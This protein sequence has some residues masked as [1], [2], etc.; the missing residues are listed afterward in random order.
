MEI[1]ICSAVKTTNGI[2]IRGHRHGDCIRTIKQMGLKPSSSPNA[3]G[4]ITSKNRFVMRQ[5]A[6]KLQEKAGIESMDPNGYTGDTLFSEDL[7]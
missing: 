4:F 6:R 2:P 1:V 7:Y 5:F 3:Q